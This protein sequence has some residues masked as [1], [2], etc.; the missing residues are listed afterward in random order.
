MDTN[1]ENELA[2]KPVG[3]LIVKYAIP[4]VISLIVTA[5]YNIVDQIFIGN[6]VGYLGNGATNV[7]F[8]IT[9]IQHGLAML[10]GCGCG[11]FLN[12]RLG[13]GKQR[14]AEKGVGNTIVALIA[15]AIILPVLCYSLVEPLV[16]LFGA[17]EGILPYALDYGKIIIIGF[18]FVI[19]Y[20]GLNQI[21]RADG[22][23]HMA[24]ISMLSGAI[25]NVFLDYLF[26]FQIP[27]GVKGAALATIIGQ[28]VS[29]FIS[30][31]YIFK[32]KHVKLD[33]KCFRMEGRIIGDVVGIG[34]SSFITQAAIVVYTA[35]MNNVL[36]Q[37]GAQSVYGPDIPI[38]AIGVVMKVNAVL[39]NIVIGIVIGGQPLISYN[40]GAKNYKRVK[41]SFKIVIL[42]SII[43]SIFAFIAFQV[44]PEEVSGIF[45]KEN[46]L[47]TEFA[48]KCF[49]IMLLLCI[50]NAFQ[51]VSG[52]FIQSIGKPGLAMLISLSR[53]MIFLIPAI[54]IMPH[55]FGIE[56][57]LWGFPI[58]DALAFILAVICIIREFKKMKGVQINEQ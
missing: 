22:N 54:L 6:A 25:L 47:Y 24:M 32:L 14:D 50:P 27:W 34:A 26:V 9:I 48:V 51:L 2:V 49:R 28:A 7:V 44:F 46:E 20:T 42:L 31:V 39:I 56:G 55:F 35:V 57:A 40:Y 16:K 4:S 52:I 18:P 37:Y 36:V 15:L 19:M 53:Q 30:L 58:A 1:I 33:R 29:F 5:L 8:P 38:A 3:K 10:L 17:T 45:G 21:I 11:A 43:I 41:E 13:Q 23:P 12:I